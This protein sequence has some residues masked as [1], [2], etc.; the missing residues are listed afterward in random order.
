MASPYYGLQLLQRYS[1]QAV[2]VK[3]TIVR[4]VS[5]HLI[6]HAQLGRTSCI[7]NE[8]WMDGVTEANVQ[9]AQA[10]LQLHYGPKLQLKR[11]DKGVIVD[12]DWSV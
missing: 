10:V 11:C 7:D 9:E 8:V 3:G 1:S 4:L 12:M 6:Q 5:E 2:D